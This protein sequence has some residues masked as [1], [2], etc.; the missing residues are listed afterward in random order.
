MQLELRR[1]VVEGLG[2]DLVEAV[3]EFRAARQAHALT[4]GEPAPL[5]HPLVEH[6]VLTDA[7]FVIVDPPVPEITPKRR[8]I[9]L[10]LLELF[11]EAERDAL[12]GSAETGV[13]L[14]LLMAAGASYVD[15]DD[16][17]TVGALDAL[18]SLGLITGPRKARI[19]SGQPPA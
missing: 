1:D 15:L 8:F 7:T 14:F 17:R 4:I 16:P 18:Q 19:L 13:K 10:E 9:F 5:A 11:T 6:I 12:V 2:F 3:A